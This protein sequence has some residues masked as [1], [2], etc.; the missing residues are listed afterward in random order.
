MDRRI[1]CALGPP[2]LTSRGGTEGLRVMSHAWKEQELYQKL[3]RYGMLLLVH[4]T[5]QGNQYDVLS[6]LV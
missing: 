1:A 2:A 5:W 4:E 6:S 3:S